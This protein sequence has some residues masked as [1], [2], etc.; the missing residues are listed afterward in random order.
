MVRKVNMLNETYQLLQP[1]YLSHMTA[2]N[3]WEAYKVLPCQSRV[4]FGTEQ[5]SSLPLDIKKKKKIPNT[6][7][8]IILSDNIRWNPVKSGTRLQLLEKPLASTAFQMIFW[9]NQSW[10]LLFLTLIN[11]LHTHHISV[12]T[13]PRK[14]TFPTTNRTVYLEH[15]LFALHVCRSFE[16]H[17]WQFFTQII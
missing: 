16:H 8:L 12:I 10:I 5:L 3:F 4:S 7:V 1:G 17:C 14:T 11:I 2:E 6:I 15:L 9:W 13:N